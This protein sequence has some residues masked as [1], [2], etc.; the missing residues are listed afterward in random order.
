MAIAT[1]NGGGYCCICTKLFKFLSIYF[2][3]CLKKIIFAPNFIGNC[4]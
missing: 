2:D 1:P 4:S 3:N